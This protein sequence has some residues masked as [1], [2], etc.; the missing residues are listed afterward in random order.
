[1]GQ[2]DDLVLRVSNVILCRIS[3]QNMLSYAFFVDILNGHVLE[4]A[5][6]ERAEN[7]YRWWVVA[8]D[9]GVIELGAD[10][11][12]EMTAEMQ[13][14]FR[15]NSNSGLV[16]PCVTSSKSFRTNAENQTFRNVG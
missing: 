16:Q 1:M 15:L 9:V 12:N 6:G 5:V 13:D 11:P 14:I 10:R 4:A 8:R 3:R 7:A 2:L